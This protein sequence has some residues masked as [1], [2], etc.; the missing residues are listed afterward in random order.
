MFEYAAD[1]VVHGRKFFVGQR[2]ALDGVVLASAEVIGNLGLLASLLADFLSVDLDVGEV[3][4]VCFHGL[5]V[6][7]GIF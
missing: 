3:D 4:S 2:I 6:C 5:N 1:N 7:L